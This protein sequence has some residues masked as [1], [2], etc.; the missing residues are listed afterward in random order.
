M[1]FLAI[2]YVNKNIEQ[3]TILSAL[4]FHINGIN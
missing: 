3:F 4:P 1:D 2:K